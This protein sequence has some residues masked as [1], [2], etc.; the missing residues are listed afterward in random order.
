[1]PA[2]WQGD[3]DIDMWERKPTLYQSKSS[4]LLFPYIIVYICIDDCINNCIHHCGHT[5]CEIYNSHEFNKYIDDLCNA[6]IN[7]FSGLI[8]DFKYSKFCSLVRR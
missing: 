1:M 4:L 5:N 2:G 7:A 8:S 6:I 3:L